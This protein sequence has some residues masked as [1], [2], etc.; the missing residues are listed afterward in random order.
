MKL[1]PKY[2]I[3]GEWG[4][5]SPEDSRSLV[6]PTSETEFAAVGLCGT[7]DLDRAVTAARRAFADYSATTPTERIAMF[8]RIV[9]VYS[10]RRP[11]LADLIAREMGSPKSVPVQTMGPIDHFKQ[12]ISLLGDYRFETRIGDAIVRREALGVCGLITPWNWPV[13]TPVTKAAYALAAGCTV[14]IKPSEY[15]PLSTLFLAEIFDQAGVPK[16]VFNVVVGDGPLLGEAMCRHSGIDMISFTGSTRAGIL[17]AS[18][19]A[20][21]VKR[22]AQ[23]LGGK[24]ANIILPDAD[25]AA[26]AR[27]TVG[28]GF[29]NSGQSC[30]APSRVLVHSSQIEEVVTHMAVEAEKIRI[31]DPADGSTAMGPVVNLGQFERIQAFIRSGIDE[32]ARLVAGGLGRPEGLERGYFVRP[33]IFADVSPDMTIAREEIFGPVLSVIAYSSEREAVEIANDSPYGL[34]GYVFTRSRETGLDISRRLRAGRVFF[35]GAAGSVAAPM[36]GYKQSGNGREMGIFG[37]EEYLEVKAIFG[38]PEE[39]AALPFLA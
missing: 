16:G 8:E 12:A 38:F 7:A 22:V 17:V 15:S 1:Y 4:D 27:W 25:L 39:A 23:E 29:F 33:T 13:Q 10:A 14:V 6:D 18:A 32:G 21:T 19:A 24:S 37:L 31:G 35:N 2:Y 28:R 3:D 30:H 9:E 20:P 5:S 36:G 11:E 34:G 26:A